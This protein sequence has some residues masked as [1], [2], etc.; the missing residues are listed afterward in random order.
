MFWYMYCFILKVIMLKTNKN[1]GK[2][3]FHTMKVELEIGIYFL[4]GIFVVCYLK[5]CTFFNAEIP[6]LSVSFQKLDIWFKVFK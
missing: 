4:A 1:W 5:L 2:S 6:L 3:Y